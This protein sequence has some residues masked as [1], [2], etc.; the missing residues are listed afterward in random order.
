MEKKYNN[1]LQMSDIDTIIK[2]NNKAIEL[3]TETSEQYEEILAAISEINI[4][5]ENIKIKQDNLEDYTFEI[6]KLL[7]ELEKA[8]F[9]LYVL[10]SSGIVSLIIQFAMLLKK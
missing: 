2:V 5:V 1:D 10:L 7:T 6:K 3:Q 9:K 4:K 8:Q